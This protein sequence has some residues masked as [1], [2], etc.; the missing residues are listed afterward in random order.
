MTA[1][2]II[3]RRAEHRLPRIPERAALHVAVEKE[4]LFTAHIQGSQTCDEDWE[5]RVND[6]VVI[7]SRTGRMDVRFYCRYFD[8][9]DWRCFG[10]VNLIPPLLE[11]TR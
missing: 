9:P 5:I 7:D 6:I 2:E 11:V 8:T 4:R 3:N 10:M 1:T